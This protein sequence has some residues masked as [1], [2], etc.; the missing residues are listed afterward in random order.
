MSYLSHRGN[1]YGYLL[2]QTLTDLYRQK[3][4]TFFIILVLAITFTLPTLSYVLWKNTQR[5]QQHFPLYGEVTLILK[6]HFSP[7]QKES[8]LTKLNAIPEIEKS[9]YVS[10][11]QQLQHLD[12]YG[13][14][15]TTWLKDMTLPDMVILYLKPTLS[16][17]TLKDLRE[18]F[19]SLKGVDN[20]QFELDFLQKINAISSLFAKIATFCALLMCSSVV[21]IINHSI[22]A[23][24]YLQ[25]QS[26]HVMQVL[27]A[28]KSFIITPFLFK[29]IG[30]VTLGSLLGCVLSF[31]LLNA[32]S[33]DVQTIALLFHQPFQLVNLNAKE[34]GLFVLL[35][36][37]LGYVSTMFATL[38]YIR[39]LR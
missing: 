4:T 26:I 31:L 24:I 10:S 30:F 36:G 15:Q 12:E 35:G 16:P 27:G 3:Y 11:A 7:E 33:Q 13:L 2:Y 18:V 19:Q 23:E 9:T 1:S 38:R 39:H 25:R 20:V 22:R 8:L 17:H 28:T 6:T 5:L 34:I 14:Q 32:F 29:G 37:V 21:L